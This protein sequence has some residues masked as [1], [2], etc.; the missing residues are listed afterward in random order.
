DAAPRLCRRRGRR[1]ADGR[2]AAAHRAAHRHA[3]PV[4]VV[5]RRHA[6]QRRAV[7][8][9][10]QGRRGR[11]QRRHDRHADLRQLRLLGQRAKAAAA[12]LRGL[13]PR[14]RERPADAAPRRARDRV[15]ARARLS[16]RLLRPAWIRDARSRTSGDAFLIPAGNTGRLTALPDHMTTLGIIGAGHIGSQVARA[17]VKAGY[18]VVIAN[19]RGPETL[20]GLVAELGSKARATTAEEA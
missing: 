4:L 15:P 13:R 18:D 10:T 17:A 6:P 14:T 19:S 2:A 1:R 3:G 11:T 9:G 16:G 20:T 7:L 12:G 5:R 8:L